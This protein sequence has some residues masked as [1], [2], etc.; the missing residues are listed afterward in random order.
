VNIEQSKKKNTG[1]EFQFDPLPET[2]T[3]TPRPIPIP[4]EFNRW[5]FDAVNRKQKVVRFTHFLG[6]F[7]DVPFDLIADHQPD[8]RYKL[9]CRL[10]ING[11]MVDLVPVA[12]RSYTRIAR[13]FAAAAAKVR[14]MNPLSSSLRTQRLSATSSIFNSASFGLRVFM[15]R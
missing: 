1:K 13:H 2:L 6:Y 3:F 12:P 8:G 7:K 14:S 10:V 9:K 4:V 11:P 15:K 5:R